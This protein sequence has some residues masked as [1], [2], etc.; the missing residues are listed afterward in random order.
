MKNTESILAGLQ[1][2]KQALNA[3]GF[4]D[5]STERELMKPQYFLKYSLYNFTAGVDC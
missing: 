5:Y 4:M 1:G 3:V 2:H